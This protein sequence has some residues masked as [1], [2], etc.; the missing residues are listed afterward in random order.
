MLIQNNEVPLYQQIKELIRSSIMSGELKP[1][2]KIS[3]ELELIDKYGVSR[4]TI[5]NSISELV[6]EGYLIKKQGKGTF[7]S[8]PK[9]QRK[10]EHLSSFSSAC[11]ANGLKAS[12]KVIRREIIEPSAEDKESL[13]L[14]EGDKLI[15]IQRLRY[16]GT[17]P[18][19]IENNYFSYKMFSFL[20]SEN[21]EGSLYEVLKN[22]YNIIPSDDAS[23]FNDTPKTSIEIVRATADQ[24]K[25]LELSLGAPLFFVNTII[26]DE[27]LCPIHIG[28]QYIK[29]ERYKFMIT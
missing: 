23:D 20:I 15:Y 17:E 28:K 18:L 14:E 4:V 8:R 26:Y 21:L 22:K 7:V 12:G 27:K 2:E 19:M 29:G 16:A 3:S 6:N 5:R 13:K 24:S 1:G 9:I 25:L 11:E 10:I